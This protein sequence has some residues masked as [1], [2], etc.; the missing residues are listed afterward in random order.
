MRRRQALLSGRRVGAAAHPTTTRAPARCGAHVRAT[1]NARTQHRGT[2]MAGLMVVGGLACAGV[3][4]GTGSPRGGRRRWQRSGLGGYTCPRFRVWMGDMERVPRVPPL[5]PRGN[6]KA[7][8]YRAPLATPGVG[9]GLTAAT[10]SSAVRGILAL[11]DQAGSQ[12]GFSAHSGSCSKLGPA[13]FAL[14]LRLPHRA[15]RHAIGGQE[16]RGR[17]LAVA[18]L[19]APQRG[20]LRLS[21]VAGLCSSAPG[22]TCGRRDQR[23]RQ[24]PAVCVDSFGVC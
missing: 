15:P 10:I 14:R 4:G 12:V 16:H 13:P 18:R 1:R 6:G 7:T 8:T 17:R 11:R 20:A 5:A 23:P 3:L 22:A 19:V 2:T 24:I 9:V 21:A